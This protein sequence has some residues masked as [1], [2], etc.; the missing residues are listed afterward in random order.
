[1]TSITLAPDV[2]IDLQMH[3][4]FSDGVWTADELLE[5]VAREGFSL[6]AVT[7]HDNPAASGDVQRL[8]AERHPGLRALSAVEMSCHWNGKMLDLLCFGFDSANTALTPIGD[9][10]R[11]RQVDNIRETYDALARMG[12]RFANQDELVPRRGRVELQFDDLLDALI[13][14][15]YSDEIEQ[16]L[17]KAGFEW[18]NEDPALIVEAAHASGAVCLIAHPGR[19]EWWPLFDAPQLDALRAVAPVDGLEVYYPLHSPES[20]AL[21][22]AYVDQHN[23]LGSA[24]SDSHGKPAQMPIKYRA[25]ISR[26]LL[27]RLGFTVR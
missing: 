7:D 9:S 24:G 22:R 15:G 26:R 8:A 23:L 11:R 1:M 16:A 17:D 10:I 25:E 27:E 4:T 2:A 5:H 20:T 21:Y 18:I 13:A 19:G 6:I 12:Y 3:S 14:N